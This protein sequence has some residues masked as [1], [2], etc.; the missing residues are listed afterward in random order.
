[1]HKKTRG[2]IAPLFYFLFKWP[3][4]TANFSCGGDQNRG[5]EKLRFC[6]AGLCAR[7]ANE[8]VLDHFFAKKFARIFCPVFQVLAAHVK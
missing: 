4:A 2:A 7:A 5:A 1:M 6:A 8:G 3:D